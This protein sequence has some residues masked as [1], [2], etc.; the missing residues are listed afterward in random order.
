MRLRNIVI[1]VLVFILLLSG[2]KEENSITK[3]KI[4]KN[5]LTI[6][7]S[8][9]PIY[10]MTLNIVK[11]IPNVEI[12]SMTRDQTGCLHDY[13]LIPDDIKCLEKADIFIVNGAGME[14]FIGKVIKQMPD[15][16]IIEASKNIETINEKDTANPHL[17]V[18]V[19]NA[20]KQV[21]NIYSQLILLDKKN[22]ALYKKNKDQYVKK[23]EELKVKMHSE[24]DNLKNRDIIT[25]H[26]A[27]PYFA[28]EF[29]LNIVRV[30]EREPGSQPSAKELAETIRIIK[31]RNV[32]GLYAEPQYPAK[33]A[34]TIAKETGLK[35]Y[36][37][38][39]C[40]T[41]KNDPDS[42]IKMMESNLE[43]LKTSLK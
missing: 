21:E 8:F 24:L 36:Y 40:V 17:W 32:K 38:D 16:K 39:P 34:E 42:Y 18:S 13:Q 23:L 37:L 27:F 30:I 4:D 35:V 10:I 7:T 33:S 29:N 43:V 2:C 20:V 28:L 5:N 26:E 25:F 41:G 1:M 9:Y 19:T 22:A 12:K 11:D 15:I 6:V 14:S 3:P 31:E